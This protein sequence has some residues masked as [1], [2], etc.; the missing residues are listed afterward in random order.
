[1]IAAFQGSNLV[2]SAIKQHHIIARSNIHV[3]RIKR[4]RLCVV[5]ASTRQPQLDKRNTGLA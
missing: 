4:Q 1:L 5:I 2:T 3:K